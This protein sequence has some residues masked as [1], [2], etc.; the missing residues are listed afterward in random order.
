[1]RLNWIL[2]RQG[3]ETGSIEDDEDESKGR[4]QEW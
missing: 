4:L 2:G 3:N 1:M